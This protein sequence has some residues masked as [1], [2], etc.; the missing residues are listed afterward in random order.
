MKT[1]I[2]TSS[3]EDIQLYWADA[4][5]ISRFLKQDEINFDSL[6]KAYTIKIFDQ[7]GALL[8]EYNNFRDGEKRL[9]LVQVALDDLGSLRRSYMFASP[10]KCYSK[11]MDT[12]R[13]NF[14]FSLEANA[15]AFFEKYQTDGFFKNLKLQI[16]SED[17]DP[18][19]DTEIDIT[20][21][22]IFNENIN[23]VFKKVLKNIESS[24]LKFKLNK[25]SFLEKEIESLL[26]IPLNE[27]MR[28]N[29]KYIFVDDIKNK[30]LSIIENEASLTV[31]F[32]NSYVFPNS[33]ELNIKYY[34]LNQLQTNVFKFFKDK[35]ISDEALL[36]IIENVA[37]N[38]NIEALNIINEEE[39]FL[40]SYQNFIYLF[41]DQSFNNISWPENPIL[42][43]GI[44]FR[45][46]FPIAKDQSNNFTYVINQL[47]NPETS[48]LSIVEDS[49]LEHLGYKFIDLENNINDY[50]ITQDLSYQKN[51]NIKN[52]AI[53]NVISQNDNVSIYLEIITNFIN[54]SNFTLQKISNNLSFVER[55]FT[56]I[57][58]N[59]H[60]T[61]LFKL[62]YNYLNTT[63]LD[64]PKNTLIQ[65]KEFIFFEFK[66]N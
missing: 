16:I 22:N 14:N 50:L 24:S 46:Y 59:N 48:A 65:N 4:I 31:P 23:T 58:D 20:F 8:R 49:R 56:N 52:I 38:Q 35:N 45:K 33:E 7:E 5:R 21:K 51:I 17:G 62:N 18:T 29:F 39:E 27:N 40:C 43:N 12:I 13:Y 10:R 19:N 41:N 44:E 2:Q 66:I 64:K 36:Q 53:K 3:S 54:T 9:S 32:P 37:E 1:L 61:L 30:W 6:I 63:L 26:I 47:N 34:Y 11:T 15:E 55:Y 60:V 28:N 25:T 42:I 57:N